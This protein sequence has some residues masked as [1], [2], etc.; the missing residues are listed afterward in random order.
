MP[1]ELQKAMK[2]AKRTFFKTGY[3]GKA[4]GEY[5]LENEAN[6][7]ASSQ[8]T[9]AG[10]RIVAEDNNLSLEGARGGSGMISNRSITNARIISNARQLPRQPSHSPSKSLAVISRF[11][12]EQQIEASDKGVKQGSL[13]GSI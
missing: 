6:F 5:L 7:P 8:Q 11:H 2:D 13:P 9:L 1:R 3:E 4:S 12:D 10:Q